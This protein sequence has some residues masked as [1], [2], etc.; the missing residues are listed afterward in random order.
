MK[1]YYYTLG[2]L[3]DL[4]LVVEQDRREEYY[5]DITAETVMQC[6]KDKLSPDLM[7]YLIGMLQGFND[8]TQIEI[9]DYML[10]FVTD[11]LITLTG[12]PS[13]DTV[14]IACYELIAQEKKFKFIDN[15]YL[16]H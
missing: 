9:A 13:V 4:A 5:T 6:L 14:L 15:Q 10:D 11:Q 3:S 16:F 12:F 7:D 1:K 2:T 8:D